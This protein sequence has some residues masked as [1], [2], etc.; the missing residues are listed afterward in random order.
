[1]TQLN[2]AGQRDAALGHPSRRVQRTA[3]RY[4]AAH[5][6]VTGICL[7]KWLAHNLPAIHAPLLGPTAARFWA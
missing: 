1:M 4:G 5:R 7:P 3:A 2:N 6:S